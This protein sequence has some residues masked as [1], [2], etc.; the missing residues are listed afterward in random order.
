MSK[1]IY[2]I[3]I[4]LDVKQRVVMVIDSLNG[5]GAEAV[6]LR[7]LDAINEKI[8]TAQAH[9]IVL[10]Q[11]GDYETGEN[12]F[13]HILNF[14]SNK[15][16]G[17]PFVKPKVV[18]EL[19]NTIVNIEREFGHI[20]GIFSHLDL[21]NMMVKSLSNNIPKYY[22]VHNSIKLELEADRKRSIFKFY[23]QKLRKKLL[24]N[25]KLICVSR[26]V[27][28]ELPLPWL[29]PKEICT[30]YNPFDVTEI[31]RLSHCQETKTYE[32]PYILHIGRLSVQKRH[33][34]LF[35]AFKALDTE[36]KLVLLTQDTKKLQK[37]IV[38]YQLTERVI[39]AGFQKNP[40]VW[41]RNADL[42]VLSSDFEGFG[43]VL[44]ESLLCETPVATTDCNHGP[45]EILADFHPEWIANDFSPQALTNV[46]NDILAQQ[47]KIKLD[48]WPLYQK[49]EAKYVGQQ[50]L[51]LLNPNNTH[52]CLG[53]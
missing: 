26:G 51:N 28:S 5:G 13:I 7:L 46:M 44:V 11:R 33:D 27:Q 15:N 32:S 37:L 12:P 52:N 49:I 35:A 41:M 31:I 6:V 34:R 43:N 1:T 25:E 18:V 23:K 36:H 29:R 40:F 22:I 2:F 45:N 48:D 30:I 24:H 19:H 14:K 4:I 50:Y 8:S 10:S 21:T 20:D 38:K 16:M 53:L 17:S 3:G 47:P 39:V 42:L 9:L